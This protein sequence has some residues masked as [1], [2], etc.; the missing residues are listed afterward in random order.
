MKPPYLR[1][2]AHE[3][4]EA[5]K[6]AEEVMRR[7]PDDL[8]DSKVVGASECA[9][10]VAAYIPGAKVVGGTC[11]GVLHAWVSVPNGPSRPYFLDPLAL[12][13]HPSVQLVSPQDPAYVFERVGPWRTADPDVLEHLHKALE[14]SG[15]TRLS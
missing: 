6:T 15:M 3:A 7:I 2:L 12:F 13:R 14:G 8:S 11:G 4:L 5:L 1:H 9:A 10:L